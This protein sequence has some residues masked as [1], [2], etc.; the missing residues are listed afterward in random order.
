MHGKLAGR[1]QMDL[2]EKESDMK[3]PK[4]VFVGLGIATFAAA[5]AVASVSGRLPSPTTQGGT[6][7]DGA[8]THLAAA[9]TKSETGDGLGLDPM[10]SRIIEER[11]ADA[12]RLKA[13][14]AAKDRGTV[15]EE[16]LLER[17]GQTSNT[18]R[19]N[20]NLD[21]GGDDVVDR[22]DVDQHVDIGRRSHLDG[23]LDGLPDE[24]VGLAGAGL[25]VSGDPP[26]PIDV[27]RQPT[28][29][30]LGDHLLADPLGLG[31]P[32][33]E[34]SI[35]AVPQRFRSLHAVAR[36]RGHRVRGLG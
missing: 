25:A 34:Q 20:G 12:A 11:Q 21:Q 15:P 26:G 22:G 27:G 19:G 4:T 24:V 13:F 23:G 30:C 10:V 18:R 6:I 1:Q 9:P 32:E 7:Q 17:I 14:R 8:T 2:M 3:M 5:L 36:W 28:A 31:V 16:I 33:G 35:C 29:P